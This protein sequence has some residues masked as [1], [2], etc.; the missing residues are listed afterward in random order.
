MNLDDWEKIFT[1]LDW[2]QIYN[3][4]KNSKNLDKKI[5]IVT[6]FVSL[7]ICRFCF[8]IKLT[9]KHYTDEISL[10]YFVLKMIL[11][12]ILQNVASN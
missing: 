8:K 10:N 1:C 12:N 4:K 3:L 9:L 2:S 5:F 6:G 11:P 7:P